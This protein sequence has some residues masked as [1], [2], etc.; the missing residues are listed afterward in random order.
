[1]NKKEKENK[2]RKQEQE[3]GME[4]RVIKRKK[5]QKETKK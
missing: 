2:K 3:T 5:H 4:K 1:M